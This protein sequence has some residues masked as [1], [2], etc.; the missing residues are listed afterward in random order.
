MNDVHKFLN[1]NSISTI[2]LKE[3]SSHSIP[4]QFTNKYEKFKYSQLC[5]NLKCKEKV[6]LII[7]KMNLGVF[8][9]RHE[10]EKLPFI[11]KCINNLIF[12]KQNFDMK[13]NCSIIIIDKQWDISKWNYKKIENI[14]TWIPHINEN[15]DSYI[16]SIDIEFCKAMGVKIEID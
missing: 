15:T 1:E 13:Y 8:L 16:N 12:K 10:A 2:Y 5:Y 14:H 3:Y 9:S 6:F 7:Q 11:D 4:Y